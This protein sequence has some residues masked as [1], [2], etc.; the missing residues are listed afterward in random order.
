[1]S[2]EQILEQVIN[3]DNVQK[4]L[5]KLKPLCETPEQFTDVSLK[6]ALLEVILSQVN[7]IFIS[8]LYPPTAKALIESAKESV[9]HMQETVTDTYVKNSLA[10]GEL[11]PIP[12]I[13]EISYWVEEVHKEIAEQLYTTGFVNTVFTPAL[14]TVTTSVIE[15]AKEEVEEV[16]EEEEE[17][18]SNNKDE[19]KE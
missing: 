16:V 4:K 7:E 1:M 19:K 18:K 17:V 14:E 8:S 10:V 9:K 11:M 15:F 5:E 2:E 13:A 12:D 3:T 6:V